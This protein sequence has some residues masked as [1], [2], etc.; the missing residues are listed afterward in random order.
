MIIVYFTEDENGDLICSH[1]IDT[2]TDQTIIMP[3]LP[4][5]WMGVGHS[6]TDTVHYNPDIGEYILNEA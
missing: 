5:N 1:G 6:K 4:L 3:Q 2:N